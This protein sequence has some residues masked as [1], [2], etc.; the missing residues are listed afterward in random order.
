MTYEDGSEASPETGVY[1]HHLLAFVPG[2][3]STNAIGLCDVED[4]AKDTGIMSKLNT[5]PLSPFT[6]RGED[7]GAVFMMF[8]SED[9]KYN[10]GFHLGKN[11]NIVVQS[12]LVNYKN[13]TQKVYLTYEYE[14][15]EGLQGAQAITTLLSVTGSCFTVGRVSCITD[16]R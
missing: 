3:P 15:V 2:K 7:G 10:S 6:G 1:I 16:N 12:D 13:E 8:T 11:D 14:Y 4:P 9:G 5:L